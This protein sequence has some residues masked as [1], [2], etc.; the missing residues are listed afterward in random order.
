MLVQLLL[1]LIASPL[2]RVLPYKSE[3]MRF[4]AS[5]GGWRREAY[6]QPKAGRNVGSR[7]TRIKAEWHESLKEGNQA[8]RKKTRQEFWVARIAA[9]RVAKQQAASL[10]RIIRKMLDGYGAN[11]AT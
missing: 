9:I 8:G 6:P 11:L 4:L 1:Y 10:E 7:S 2:S 3:I 5:T